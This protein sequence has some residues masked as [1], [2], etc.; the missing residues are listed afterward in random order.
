M[1]VYILHAASS[2]VKDQYACIIIVYY[3]LD[4][5][6]TPTAQSC[7]HY[8]DVFNIKNSRKLLIGI[9]IITRQMHGIVSEPEQ[10]VHVQ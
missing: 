10:E 6:H 2:S 1:I 4:Y 5:A 7:M 3:A 9:K 8:S